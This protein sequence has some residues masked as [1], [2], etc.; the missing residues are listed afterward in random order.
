MRFISF[1]ALFMIGL[2]SCKSPDNFSIDSLPKPEIKGGKPLM[3]ALRD[4][5][6]NRDFSNKELPI[7]RLSNLLWAAGGVNRPETGGRTFPSA[8]NRQEIDIYVALNSGVFIYE[9]KE[10]KLNQ[11]LNEDIRK[12]IGSQ[13]FLKVAP[14]C[15]IFVANM[16]KACGDDSSKIIYT[17]ADAAYISE[18]IYLFCASENLATVVMGMVDCSFL[19]EKLSLRKEQ[20]IILA[21]P[22]GYKK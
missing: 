9:F 16:D 18:N 7:Q 20:K 8:C 13:E 19:S 3:L 21:Q 10:H 17:A 22:V 6:T 11:V 1:L 14:L 2:I 15:F 4:R 5:S 12:S